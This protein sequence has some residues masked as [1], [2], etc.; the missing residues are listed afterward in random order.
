MKGKMNGQAYEFIIAFI[1]IFIT[2]ILWAILNHA[3][4]DIGDTV[5]DLVDSQEHRDTVRM[6]QAIFY[7]SLFFLIIVTFIYVLK[8][9][10]AKGD[11]YE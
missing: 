6:Q 11:D 10:L 2:I 5:H 1:G 8:V 7:Y 9:S 4:I 3:F